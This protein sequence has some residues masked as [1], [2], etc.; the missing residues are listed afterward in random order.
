MIE[1][2]AQPSEG[3][4]LA[5]SD[6]RLQMDRTLSEVRLG[7][8]VICQ[9]YPDPS[10]VQMRMFVLGS[11]LL[12]KG[13]HT[14]VNLEI[15]SLSIGSAASCTTKDPAMPGEYGQVSSYAIAMKIVWTTSSID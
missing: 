2:C 15:G 8:V 5:P 6:W 9:S 13:T 12:F 14:F 3:S 11:Y 7:K 4:A 10:D 1:G